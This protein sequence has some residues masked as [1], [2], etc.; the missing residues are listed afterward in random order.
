MPRNEERLATFAASF[1]AAAQLREAAAALAGHRAAHAELRSSRCFGAALAAALALGNF[2]NHGSRLGQAVGFRLKNLPKL[3]VTAACGKSR[4]SVHPPAPCFWQWGG[5]VGIE[6]LKTAGYLGQN[7]KQPVRKQQMVLSTHHKP[8][9]PVGA[10]GHALTGRPH[11]AAAIRRQA[12]VPRAPAAL[13]GGPPRGV[14]R[15][16]DLLVGEP[17][18]TP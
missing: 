16:T 11:D 3:Q 12:A 15:P 4:Q 5:N 18:G 6:R 7:R 14:P 10:P 13:R 9:C 1:E 2:L 8:F 17:L